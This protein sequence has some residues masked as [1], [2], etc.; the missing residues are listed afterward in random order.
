MVY[1]EGICFIT[2]N[3]KIIPRVPYKSLNYKMKYSLSKIEL[4][5][6]IY[7]KTTNLFIKYTWSLPHPAIYV[8]EFS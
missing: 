5:V 7:T 2:L 8:H 1:L 4:T 6:Q 3:R